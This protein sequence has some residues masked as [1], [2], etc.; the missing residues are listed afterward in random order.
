MGPEVALAMR[1]AAA[2]ESK[3]KPYDD[4]I[5]PETKTLPGLFFVH[6][7]EDRIMYEIPVAELGKEML[8]VTQIEKT[9]AGAGYGGSPAGDRVVRWEQRG[10]D[11]LLRDVTFDI[12]AE[13]KDPIKDAVQ[14]SSVEPIIA[15][16]AVKAYGKDKAPVVDVTELFVSDT[17]EFGVGRRLNAAGNDPRKTFIEQV[18]PF[19]ENIES[20]ITMTFRR[21]GGGD[22]LRPRRPRTP[23]RGR[24]RRAGRQ[25]HGPGPPQH[26]QAARGAD[27][28]EE[29]RRPRRLLHRVVPGLRRHHQP[30]GRERPVHHPMAAGEEG[31]LGRPLR[32]QASRSSSTSAARSPTSSA[33][34]S[35]R[36]SS[37]GSRRSRRPASR[38]PSSA[39]TPPPSARTPTGTPRTPA[40]RRSAGSPRRSRTPWGRTSTT[41]GP[42]RSSRPTS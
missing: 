10:D 23:G 25:R 37:S 26:D 36:G 12:R 20:K 38:T 16:L 29:V 9:G 19:P 39:R 41:R 35:R 15:V 31:P 22:H 28:A 6:R 3:I 18:K 4:I 21:G 5:T 8:W 33:R 1:K 2:K 34:R 30:S 11:V 17:P 24:R 32:A 14:A 7:L 27:E 42:A 13:T 40:T